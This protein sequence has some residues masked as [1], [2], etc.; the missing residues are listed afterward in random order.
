MHHGNTFIYICK[1]FADIFL[2]AFRIG[3]YQNQ[4]HRSVQDEVSVRSNTSA[5]IIQ[6]VHAQS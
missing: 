2:E 4:H 6:T 1:V 5:C 3:C